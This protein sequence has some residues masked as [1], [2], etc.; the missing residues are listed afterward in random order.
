VHLSGASFEGPNDADEQGA[1]HVLCL[2]CG[3][4]CGDPLFIALCPRRGDEE[5][6]RPLV[7]PCHLGV[8]LAGDKVD[9][10]L[11]PFPHPLRRLLLLNTQAGRSRLPW[12]L[13]LQ[14]FCPLLRRLR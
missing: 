1:Q 14:L 12:L 3:D 13:L 7:Q 4:R 8:R 2:R 9:R 11:H 5:R 10:P 6:R